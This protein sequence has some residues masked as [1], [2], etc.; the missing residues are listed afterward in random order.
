[1]IEDK[2]PDVTFAS[3]TFMQKLAGLNYLAIRSE[4]GNRKKFY[5]FSLGLPLFIIVGIFFL[6][7]R[8]PNQPYFKIEQFVVCGLTFFT[9]W[10][11]TRLLRFITPDE[12][13]R[14]MD[15]MLNS[16][17]AE[18][19]KTGIRYSLIYAGFSVV[20][21]TIIAIWF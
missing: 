17:H 12:L 20:V 15:R 16:Q 18:I 14:D 19:R 6:G 2:T 5:E 13:K 8:N 7:S 4:E 11:L 9:V 21:I 3:L 10:G 1:M